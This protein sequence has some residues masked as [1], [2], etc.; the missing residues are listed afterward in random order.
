MML[1]A[2]IAV[3]GLICATAQFT[4]ADLA[5]IPSAGPETVWRADDFLAPGG[6]KAEVLGG[7]KILRDDAG[8]YAF[9]NG[10]T[11]G[12]VIPSAPLAGLRA[13]TVEV[14]LNP[15]PGGPQ[16]QRF[17]HME[18]SEGRR[19]T[20]EIRLTPAGRWAL[21]TF[22]LA[23]SSRR[24]LLDEKLLHTSGGWHWVALRYDGRTMESFV[25]GRKELDG[26][27][28][29]TPMGPGRTAIGVR[30]NRIFWYRGAI[31]E[32]IIHPVALAGPSLQSAGGSPR[33]GR[34]P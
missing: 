5:P 26:R 6:A 34:G 8:S 15:D 25:D 12:F 30:L 14:L 4:R 21:D 24:A 22:L 27:V 7:P 13:F 32:I 19:L 29:F 17:L 20:M 9:F 16:A 3:L 18:D 33:A 2:W 31:R 28:D 23:G 10:R 11:D 1:N